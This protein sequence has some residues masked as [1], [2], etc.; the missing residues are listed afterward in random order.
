MIHLRLNLTTCNLLFICPIPCLFLFLSYFFKNNLLFLFFHFI[1]TNDLLGI[2]LFYHLECFLSFT[3]YILKL[4]QPISKLC[5]ISHMM[6]DAWV[7]WSV[8]QWALDFSSDHDLRVLESSTSWALCSVGSL[9]KDSLSPSAPPTAHVCA[10][11]L[12]VK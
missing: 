12:S 4:I 9:L 2:F 6:W 1:F 3:I 8:E 7:A 5:K 11:S 10:L